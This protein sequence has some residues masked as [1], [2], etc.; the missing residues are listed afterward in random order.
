[1]T[2]CMLLVGVARRCGLDSST[3]NGGKHLPSE[4]G[5]HS[6]STGVALGPDSFGLSVVDSQIAHVHGTHDSHMCDWFWVDVVYPPGLASSI[7]ALFQW[8]NV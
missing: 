7:L 2:P 4:K 3:V 8:A 5:F 6:V 1:M